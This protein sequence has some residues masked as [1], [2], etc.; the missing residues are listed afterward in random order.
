MIGIYIHIPFCKGKCPYCDFYSLKADE[1]KKDSYLKAVLFELKRWKN[2][3]SDEIDTVYFGGG[4]P[5]VFGAERIKKVIDCIRDNYTLVSPQITVECN[6]SSTDGEFFKVLSSA[7]VNRISMGMQSAVEKERKALGRESNPSMI[8]RA[9]KQ[10]KSAGIADISLDLML[11][12]PFQDM[13]SLDES[14]E[15]ILSMDVTHIS[16]YMLKIEED[17][18]FGKNKNKLKLPDEDEVCDMYLHT[19][20]RLGENGFH[21]Y[22]ISNFCRE[23]C[24]SRHNLKY[25]HCEQYLGIGPGAHSFLGGKRFYFPR[26]ID[27]FIGGTDIVQDGDGG[28]EDEYIMLCLRLNEGLVFEKYKER[29]SRLPRESIIKKAKLFEEK[30]LLVCDEKAIRLNEKG[31]LL[32]NTIISQLL[33]D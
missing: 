6:A 11:G 3:I 25:W 20:R 23:G 31:F 27:L 7:G 26:D 16:A 5:S 13:A 18:P 22:E 8:E 10:A 15:S 1:S 30:G 24:E 12:V 21:Q 17:T 14:I 32:S 2:K 33:W 29:F 9:V 19:V 4:T 28:S